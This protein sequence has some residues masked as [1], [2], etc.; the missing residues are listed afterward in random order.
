MDAIINGPGV[1]LVPLFGRVA[2]PLSNREKWATMNSVLVAHSAASDW[3]RQHRI[4]D[5]PESLHF[6]CPQQLP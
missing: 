4:M 6:P 1:A 3:A 2:V 5:H